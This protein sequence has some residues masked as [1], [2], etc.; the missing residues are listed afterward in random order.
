MY[1]LAV[2][3]NLICVLPTGAGKTRIAVELA[4]TAILKFP[5][6]HVIFLAPTIPLAQQQQNTLQDELRSV[7][8]HGFY[9]GKRFTPPSTWQ[10]ASIIVATPQTLV[11]ELER[12]GFEW[13]LCSLLILDEC[14]HTDKRHPYHVIMSRYADTA[15][16]A[17]PRVLGLTASPVCGI[18]FSDHLVVDL[19]KRMCCALS[20]VDPRTDA[21]LDCQVPT[22]QLHAER[23]ARNKRTEELACAIDDFFGECSR[24]LDVCCH[25]AA[26][27]SEMRKV[28]SRPVSSSEEG[29][30]DA[31]NALQSVDVL[32]RRL[33][34]MH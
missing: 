5:D 12:D 24:F 13:H 15:G 28:L 34:S 8:C 20:Y 23:P 3:T 31:S 27:C 16:S 19:C 29:L 25:H 1:N 22:P 11:N 14:H 9:G 6:R 2:D 4:R 17:K 7:V 32:V 33:K 18:A 30:I 10:K 21:E 26:T